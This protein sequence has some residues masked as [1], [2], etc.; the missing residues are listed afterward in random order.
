MDIPLKATTVGRQSSPT[1]SDRAR[2][3]CQIPDASSVGEHLTPRRD[4]HA[5]DTWSF[6]TKE[7]DKTCG[8]SS[9]TSVNDRAWH[10]ICVTPAVLGSITERLIASTE[11][12]LVAVKK[13]GTGLS[14]LNAL[15][16]L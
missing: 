10:S 9:I 1:A 5:T 11:I 6:L 2:P 15:F 13:K 4:R 3:G 14:L 16:P 12:P 8:A 7:S